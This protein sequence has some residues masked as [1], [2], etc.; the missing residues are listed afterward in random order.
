LKGSAKAEPFL[1]RLSGYFEPQ[2]TAYKKLTML[3]WTNNF[4]IKHSYKY[5]ENL[6]AWNT[7]KRLYRWFY[8]RWY[9]NPP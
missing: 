9:G 1:L 5:G 4:L 3:G 7:Q 6:N 8:S 2:Y